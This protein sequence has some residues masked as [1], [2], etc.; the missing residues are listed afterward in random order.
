MYWDEGKFCNIVTKPSWRDS[1][2]IKETFDLAKSTLA[3]L[4]LL[5]STKYTR[6]AFVS[7]YRSILRS[8]TARR[9][10]IALVGE[11]F[12][13]QDMQCGSILALRFWISTLHSCYNDTLTANFWGKRPDYNYVLLTLF[14][15]K[16]KRESPMGCKG[17]SPW[18]RNTN[19]L[20]SPLGHDKKREKPSRPVDWTSDNTHIGKCKPEYLCGA[21]TWNI[22]GH[23]YQL[24]HHNQ[25]PLL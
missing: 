17:V 7:L 2:M 22:W 23:K 5:A 24:W 8:F 12:P 1:A 6:P 9:L 11:V 3:Y 25:T 21:M 10:Y 4:A 20:Y 16:N 18:C 14:Q 13:F 15:T 19:P